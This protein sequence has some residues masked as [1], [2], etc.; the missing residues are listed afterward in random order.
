MGKFSFCSVPPVG[1]GR[2][3]MGRFAERTAKGGSLGSRFGIRR[4]TM[5]TGWW[6]GVGE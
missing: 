5:S 1:I 2:W 6:R 4:E 3:K